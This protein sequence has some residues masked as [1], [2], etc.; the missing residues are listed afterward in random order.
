[1][2]IIIVEFL[3]QVKKIIKNK[4]SFARDVIVSLDA[5]SSYNLRNNKIPYYESY[6]F[7]NHR[8]LWSQYKEITERTIKITEV[9]DQA[10]WNTDKRFRD[11]NW[12]FFNEKCKV[13][14][15]T[16]R[17]FTNNFIE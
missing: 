14:K 11:L 9:L 12:K 6:E 15:G 3:W 17:Y 13:I 5:E 2:R 1:M 10:L 16:I 4:N 8:K 7:C